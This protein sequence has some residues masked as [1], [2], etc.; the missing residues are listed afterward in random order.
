MLS[1]SSQS[2]SFYQNFKNFF[3]ESRVG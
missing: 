2:K 1:S 3:G